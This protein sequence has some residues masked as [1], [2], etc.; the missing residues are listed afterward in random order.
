MSVRQTL[1]LLQSKHHGATTQANND[2]YRRGLLSVTDNIKL[3]RQILLVFGFALIIV[4]F[5][6]VLNKLPLDWAL[7]ALLVATNILL[8]SIIA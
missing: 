7:A 6:G 1:K 3:F 4:L 5:S 2:L 8:D